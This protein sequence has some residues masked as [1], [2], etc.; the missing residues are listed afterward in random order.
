MESKSI[1]RGNLQVLIFDNVFTYKMCLFE[2][3]LMS[4]GKSR[5]P[6]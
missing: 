5:T 2:F 6:I 1:V 3:I 4:P